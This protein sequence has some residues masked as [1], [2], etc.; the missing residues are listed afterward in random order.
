[1]AT[2]YRFDE[3]TPRVGSEVSAFRDLN[4]LKKFVRGQGGSSKYWEITGEI[5]KDE[6]GPDGL[7]IRVS[8]YREIRV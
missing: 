1:M 8:S 4:S 7:T 3:F 5:V 6:G 2:G